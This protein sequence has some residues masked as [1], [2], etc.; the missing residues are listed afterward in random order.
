MTKPE[1]QKH[2]RRFD[3][4]PAQGY[5]RGACRCGWNIRTPC[6]AHASPMAATEHMEKEFVNH[7]PIG[8]RMTHLLVNEYAGQEEVIALPAGVKVNMTEFSVVDEIYYGLI[9]TGAIL[10]IIEFR[11]RD[12]RVLKTE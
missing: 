3:P 12:G 1:I 4:M 6:S 10:P 8:E 11:L 9:E 2:V 7:L 5:H